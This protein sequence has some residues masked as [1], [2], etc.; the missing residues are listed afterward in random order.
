MAPNIQAT[1]RTRSRR[2][3]SWFYAAA[4]SSTS[5]LA[6][7]SC[8]MVLTRSHSTRD[9][10]PTASTSPSKPFAP[11]V[12][13]T[14]WRQRDYVA[15]GLSLQGFFGCVLLLDKAQRPGFCRLHS[16]AIRRL[17]RARPPGPVDGFGNF[18]RALP[19]SGGDDDD[20]PGRRASGGLAGSIP[21][22]SIPARPA[23]VWGASSPGLGLTPRYAQ[24]AQFGSA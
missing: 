6:F 15:S 24:A 23:R 19:L 2:L 5:S 10:H 8:Y 11:Y 14:R 4:A 1:G 9:T 20:E 12:M 7:I 22:G 17:G 21:S 16:R 13:S 3:P 18:R